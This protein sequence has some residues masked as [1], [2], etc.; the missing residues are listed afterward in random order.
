MSDER[1]NLLGM[2]KE[3]LSAF[4]RGIGEAPYRGS[5]LYHWLYAGGATSFASMTDLGKP[6]RSRLEDAARIG[7]VALRARRRSEQDGTEKLLFSLEDGL[8]IESV[9]IPPAF[10]DGDAAGDEEQK[11]L[12]M[13]VST[14]V[15]CPLDC[16]FCATGTMG[17]GRNLTAG[18]IVAQVLAGRR[19]SG[20]KITN[21]VFMGMG[22]PLLNYDAVMKAAGLLTTGV[23]ITAR[24]ITVSTAGRVEEIRRMADEKQRINL[25]VSLHSAVD[26]TRTQL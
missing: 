12:T 26:E 7:V 8:Q 10:R 6:F 1:T 23:G 20:K 24:R 15:G 19:E 13:C 9:L 18:E 16:A 25:A 3:E 4:A 14:Q 11:R 21:V 2:T 17:F 5:Q 22:E